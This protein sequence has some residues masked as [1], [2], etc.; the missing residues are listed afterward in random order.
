MI[1]DMN[2]RPIGIFD[3]GIGGLTVMAEIMRL[4]PK[5]RIIYFGDTARVPYGSKSQ[6]AVTRFSLEIASFLRTQNV[7]MIVV[8]CNTASAFALRALQKKLDIP[9][10]G[11]IE[12]G[13]R[14]ALAATRNGRIGIIGTEGTIRSS[15]YTRAIALLDK[16]KKTFAKAC[17]LFVPL[18]EEGWLN[19]PV[20]RQVAQVYLKPL[21]TKNVDTLVLGCTHYPLVKKVIRE[22]VGPGIRLI[23]SATATALEVAST[24]NRLELAA[25]R[26]ANAGGKRYRF[27]V[28]DAP[29]KFKIVG[30][31]FLG[32][33][34][35]PVEKVDLNEL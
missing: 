5:E 12:P 22:V 27:F 10:V 3:S 20:T 8:A 26:P 15:S 30:Q 17:P 7:K 34:V 13:A 11:V 32:K 6:G 18:V 29:E 33:S 35:T 4:L 28:S 14:S 9:V 25:E 21:V 24:L 16:K 23:D 19:H 2:N 1:R 31:R